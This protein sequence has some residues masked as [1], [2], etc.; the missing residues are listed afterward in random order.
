MGARLEITSEGFNE[1]LRNLKRRRLYRVAVAY[2]VVHGHF[3]QPRR[4][5]PWTGRVERE[6]TA[7]PWHDWNE[8]PILPAMK[9]WWHWQARWPT[10]Y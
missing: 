8:R 7:Y 10:G 9:C 6:V 3:Y 4:D 1:S 2:L 5:N